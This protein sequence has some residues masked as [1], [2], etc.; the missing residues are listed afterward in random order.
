[1]AKITDFLKRIFGQTKKGDQQVKIVVLDK[2]ALEELLHDK[3]LKTNP[4]AANDE[5]E[6]LSYI[7][8]FLRDNR[9]AEA[10]DI[11]VYDTES[12]ADLSQRLFCKRTK[13]TAVL[14]LNQ[15]NVGVA[16]I[17]FGA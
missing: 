13:R 10:K 8:T 9:I 12:P 16:K 7:Y 4:K 15:N 17:Y 3:S 14:N 5:R 11:I 2:E 6:L 1:M